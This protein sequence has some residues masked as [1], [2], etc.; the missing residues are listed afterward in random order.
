MIDVSVVTPSYN[1]AEFLPRVW[2][3]LKNQQAI[4]EW[5]V[6]DDGSSDNSSDVCN[7][8][9]DSR[10]NYYKLPKNRGANAARNV[11]VKNANGRFIVFL[12]SDDEL[13]SES[14][15]VMVSEMNNARL[16][17]GAI[18]FTCLIAETGEK[19]SPL[20]D[21]RTL[22]EFDIVCANDFGKGDRILVYRREVF[23]T[24]QLPEEVRGCEHVFVYEVSKKWIY[25]L[26]NL[27]LSIVHRQ[28]D[29]LSNS[30]SMVARSFDIAKSFEMLIK[31]HDNVLLK[32]PTARFRFQKKAL[33]R[34]LV[35]GHREEA[36]RLYI[37]II[38]QRRSIVQIVLA[39][40]ILVCGF[41]N[42]ARFE[43]WRIDRLNRKLLSSYK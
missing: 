13:V 15:S 1:R 3:S 12:D 7:S 24:Y 40:M 2:Q 25:L 23:E 30:V 18:A 4:F 39:T 10:I 21:G 14:L 37:S 28:S 26:R 36:W 17:I 5:I 27:P 38:S 42:L 34:Y 29:N 19:V 31:N 41:F 35:A 20:E 22:N 6:V 8:F 32:C 33:Y 11:G 43:Q 9:N 16:E